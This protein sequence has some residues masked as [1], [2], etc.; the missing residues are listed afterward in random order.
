MSDDFSDDEEQDEILRLFGPSIVGRVKS[1][2]IGVFSSIEMQNTILDS[3]AKAR[4]PSAVLPVKQIFEETKASRARAHKLDRLV[5]E[6]IAQQKGG[7]SSESVSLF[8]PPTTKSAPVV[9]TQDP[10][11]EERP[12]HPAIAKTVNHSSNQASKPSASMDDNNDEPPPQKEDKTKTV[13]DDKLLADSGVSKRG[14]RDVQQQQ[15]TSNVVPSKALVEKENQDGDLFVELQDPIEYKLAERLVSLRATV[16]L[17]DRPS[18]EGEQVG[19]VTMDSTILVD[20]MTPT[21]FRVCRPVRAWALRSSPDGQ[22]LFQRK[23]D[24]APPSNVVT[25]EVSTS[26]AKGMV[27]KEEFEALLERVQ[28]LEQELDA[29]RN[30]L[31]SV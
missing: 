2:E 22:L 21:W 19:L 17:R 3:L 24:D 15:S 13:S 10:L 27:S 11:V 30:V 16:R 29:V 18:P 14:F 7:E 25:N 28:R 12:I 26:A 5:S 31:R 9:R 23:I 20:G 6:R 4:D 1:G 8:P